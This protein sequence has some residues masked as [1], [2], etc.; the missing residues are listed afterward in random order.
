[1]NER[2]RS[3]QQMCLLDGAVRYGIIY[4]Q[5]HTLMD[6]I[7]RV[8]NLDAYAQ[9]MRDE[10]RLMLRLSPASTGT[11]DI[12]AQL[13]CHSDPLHALRCV[14]TPLPDKKVAISGWH[15]E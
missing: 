13:C 11:I 14:V 3:E 6:G 10:Y 1:M 7:E 9:L 5:H 15:I 8:L 4:A 2:M 12:H